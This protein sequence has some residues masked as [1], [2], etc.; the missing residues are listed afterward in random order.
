MNA[1]SSIM[2]DEL[3]REIAEVEV[4]KAENGPQLT[5]L[6]KWFMKQSLA[7]KAKIASIFSLGGL[8]LVTLIAQ[9]G[10]FIPSFA[11]IAQVLTLVILG[12]ALSGGIS[13]LRFV[14]KHIIEPYLKRGAN[15][16]SRYRIPIGRMR[17]A[18]SPV[19][20]RSFSA[21]ATSSTSYL[22]GA[23]ARPRNARPS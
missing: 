3:V 18:I 16:I 22:P 11:P 9:I 13:S 8:A 1:H 20:S 6:N 21:R 2:A 14:L 17:S 15:A 4:M 19:P 10:F 23:S 7:S 5:G 12:I